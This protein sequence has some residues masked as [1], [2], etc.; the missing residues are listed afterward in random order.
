MSGCSR[1][2]SLA[3][4][5]V[6]GLPEWDPRSFNDNIGLLSRDWAGT[7]LQLFRFD[8]EGDY[9][10][11]TS[12]ASRR[13]FDVIG[14]Q[15]ADGTHVQQYEDTGNDNQR[16][17]LVPN[18]DGAGT[19]IRSKLD[20]RVLTLSADCLSPEINGCWIETFGMQAG[21]ASQLW[22]IEPLTQ[23]PFKIVGVNGLVVDV[24][25][26]QSTDG[27][28]VQQY[29]D[30][31]GAN[32]QWL[33]L[34]TEGDFK[35]ISPSTGLVLQVPP[36]GPQPNAPVQQGLDVNGTNQAWRLIPA[37][38][39]G[40]PDYVKIASAMDTRFVLDVPDGRTDDR[41]PL[42]VFNDNEGG[43]QRWQFVNLPSA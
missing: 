10:R 15:R 34:P 6:I 12:L 13:V 39:E 8:P 36:E 41:V 42:Q 22:S 2:V 21:Q 4:Q 19:F 25:G 24:P 29:H 17:S 16:W 31:N 30:H 20:G 14:Q 28:Q 23:G 26:G 40:I 3:N 32:Q 7:T 11:I 9:F 1:I 18:P 35:I 27:L 43:N 5:Q 33:V 37:L 38:F